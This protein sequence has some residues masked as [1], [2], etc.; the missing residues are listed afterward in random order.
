MKHHLLFLF[1]L[2]SG[3]SFGRSDFFGIV[4]PRQSP[5]SYRVMLGLPTFNYLEYLQLPTVYSF[6]EHKQV[7]MWQTNNLFPL[8]QL[9]HDATINIYLDEREILEI[10]SGKKPFYEFEVQTDPFSPESTYLGKRIRQRTSSYNPFFPS[11]I[12]VISSD[13]ITSTITTGIVSAQVVSIIIDSDCIKRAGILGTEHCSKTVVYELVNSKDI[14]I[15]GKYVQTS[16]SYDSPEYVGQLTSLKL[17]KSSEG[18]IDVQKFFS[19]FGNSDL[20]EMYPS[21]YYLGR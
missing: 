2:I 7:R 19:S 21:K 11:A 5:F 9:N 16:I 18:H 1:M 13:V 20:R 12:P 6:T 3:F 14:E 17:M 15:F 10:M 8:F 4:G